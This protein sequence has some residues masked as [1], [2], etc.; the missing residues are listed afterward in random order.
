MFRVRPLT[1]LTLGCMLIAG[2]VVSAQ[3]RT[4]TKPVK[5][6]VKEIDFDGLKS[7]LTRNPANARP[8]LVNFWAT[9]CDPCREEFPDLLQIN[10]DYGRLGLEFA[11]VSLDDRTELT[12]GVPA[13]LAEMKAQVPAY[14]LNV[15]DPEPAIKYLDNSWSGALPATFLYDEDG[16]VVYKHF[17]RV[18]VG[19]LRAA[20]NKVVR[21][22][23]NEASPR[24]FNT[25]R[26]VDAF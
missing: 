23:T 6:S 1:T 21:R 20:I 9:W 14:L 18:P 11:A 2:F 13:F 5:V 7:L 8:L 24:S 25:T 15:N 4:S 3:T 19:E 26:S 10:S 17:G 12:T 16:K 22:K